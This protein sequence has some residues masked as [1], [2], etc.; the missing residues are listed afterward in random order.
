VGQVCRLQTSP[1]R[2]WGEFKLALG[3]SLKTEP[4]P[5]SLFRTY[6]L[7]WALRS[8]LSFLG[9]PPLTAVHFNPQS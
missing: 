4:D 3:F 8:R 2:S 9:L 5:G 6:G 7:Q 1:L